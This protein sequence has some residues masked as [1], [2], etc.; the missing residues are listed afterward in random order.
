MDA[1]NAQSTV[2]EYMCYHCCQEQEVKEHTSTTWEEW[3]MFC[4][5]RVVQMTTGEFRR[6]RGMRLTSSIVLPMAPGSTAKLQIEV[7][8]FGDLSGNGYAHYKARILNDGNGCVTMAK[9][10]DGNKN[11][12]KLQLK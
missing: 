3:A 5:A 7:F 10:L 11:V 12:R 9:A 8:H 6:H 1:A 2:A 4:T